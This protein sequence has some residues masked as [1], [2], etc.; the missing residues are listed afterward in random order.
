MNGAKLLGS[1]Q[2]ASLPVLLAFISALLWGLWWIP[3]RWLNA[4][5]LDAAWASVAMNAG[6]ATAVLTWLLIT[7]VAIRLDA[8]TVSGALLAG[9]A[10]SSYSVA[11]NLSDVV[12]VI[13]LFYLAPAWSKIIEWAFMGQRWTWVS[14]LTISL[15]LAGAYFVLGGEVSLASLNIGDMLALISGLSW[16]I[17]AALIFAGKPTSSAT[18]SFA[19]A[20]CAL[21]VSV[22]FLL[23]A[24]ESLVLRDAVSSGNFGLGAGAGAL[25]VL[26]IL[27]L[28]MWT[29]Q[30]L[31]P[32]VLTFLLTAEILSG[33]LSGVIFL[34]EPFG[35]M[36][37]LGAVLILS[38][39]AGEVV[40]QLRTK[41]QQA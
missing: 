29:A 6:A 18:L 32:A 27:V 30:R 33:V 24:P 1:E 22:I 20:F 34:D 31:T 4:Q 10:V 28:T 9:V 15:S 19:A 5:G 40:P 3:V 35:W 12:R 11:L 38:A 26:P 39:A 13:L 17:G 25:Y 14:S 7:R 36:Q 41:A 21:M 23:F 37:A 16:A 2:P 8:R